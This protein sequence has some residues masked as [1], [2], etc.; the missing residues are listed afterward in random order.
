MAPFRA[1]QQ[2]HQTVPPQRPG[3][4]PDPA[5]NPRNRDETGA[6]RHAAPGADHVREE[7]PSASSG[8]GGAAP[9][10][11]GAGEPHR[12]VHPYVFVLDEHHRPL[13]PC[14]PARARK[15]LAKGRALA[16][17]HTPVVVRR[18]DRAALPETHTFGALCDGKTGTV[19]GTA[20][21]VLAASFTGRGTHARTRADRN[22]PPRLYL[23]R[24]KAFSGFQT[25]DLVRA[26]VPKGKNAGTHAVRAAVHSSGE[27]TVTTARG[28]IQGIHHRHVRVVQ[29]ADGYAYTIRKEKGVP[30]RP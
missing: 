15:L 19:T 4:E 2:S 9:E 22:G 10:P 23:P 29:R 5:D 30:S 24:T 17:R 11:C 28:T 3:L 18:R 6:G 21:S 25:G 1:A 26:I 14:S 8:A 7:T 12:E 27:F 13:R 20:A 16:H